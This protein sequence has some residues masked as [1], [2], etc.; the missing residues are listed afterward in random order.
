MDCRNRIEEW[1]VASRIE[2]WDAL[3]PV[4]SRQKCPL[5]KHGVTGYCVRTEI[6][7]GSHAALSEA[8]QIDAAEVGEVRRC[9]GDEEV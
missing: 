3:V 4:H 9:A 6:L 8:A 7:A 2:P 5:S 1:T